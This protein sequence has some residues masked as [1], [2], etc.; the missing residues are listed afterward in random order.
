MAGTETVKTITTHY[1]AGAGNANGGS[2]TFTGG[3]IPTSTETVVLRRAVPKHKR[4][5]ISLMIHS[6][7]NH[8]KR[9]WIVLQ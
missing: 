9:V 3:N 4:L 1:T 2:I 7:R 8:T 5:T 6:L